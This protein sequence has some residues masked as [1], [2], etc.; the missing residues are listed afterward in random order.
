MADTNV[1]IRV[2]VADDHELMRSG[3]RRA[4]E[5]SDD[6]EIVVEARDGIEVLDALGTHEIDVCL[7]DLRM[8]RLDGMDCLREI[9]SRHPSMPVIMLTVDDNRETALQALRLGA[10]GYILKSVR[11]TDLA[12]A[13]SQAVAGTVW[14]GGPRVAAI[15]QEHASQI[16]APADGV[17]MTERELEILRLVARGQ[18]NADIARTLYVTPKTVKFHLT[19]IF[20]KLGVTN[21][22]E[23]AAYAFNKGLAPL[24]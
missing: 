14:M 4:L 11:P 7:I 12:A 22:T 19:N 1:P 13:I 24:N 9:V 16:H 15:L 10:A 18:S 5:L 6:I 17:E 8:P 23:A 20:A 21:R 3:I 2:L